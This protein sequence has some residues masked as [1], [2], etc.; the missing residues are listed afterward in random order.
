M[1]EP[2]YHDV[3]PG[4]VAAIVTHLEMT[5]KP[6][7]RPETDRGFIL[8]R[9]SS[10]GVDW[11][12]TLFRNVGA[13]DWLWFS[14]LVMEDATLSGILTDKRVQVYALENAA[15][16]QGLLELDFRQDG[17]CELAFFGVSG[18]LIG[19]GAG[20]WMMNRAIELAFAENIRRFHVHTCSLDHPA[21]LDFYRRS[22]FLPTRRQVEIAPDPRLSG[23]LSERAAPQV[24]ILR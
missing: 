7:L 13:E 4:H 14:R 18:A 21:A 16:E 2:G 19:T 9:I 8:R 10:P 15:Q 23:L 17:Q 12:R 22:G 11:Y 1:L 6:P 24:P 3:P 20:R 5:E